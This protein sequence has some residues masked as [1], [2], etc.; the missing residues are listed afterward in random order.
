MKA[1][2]DW[3][4]TAIDALDKAYVPYSHF[5][6]GA[7]LVTKDGKAYQGLNIENAS[8]GLSNCAERTAIFK[9]ISEGEREFQHLVVAGHT[10]EPIA[11]C[12]ACRQVIAEFCQADMPVTLVG[13]DGVTKETTV[14]ELLP[15]SFTNK[16]L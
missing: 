13:D 7:C 5:P 14:G 2:E 10:P 16:D 15:Y 12:G 1:K 11:P 9:A 6:V 4:Q 8:Y 3:I